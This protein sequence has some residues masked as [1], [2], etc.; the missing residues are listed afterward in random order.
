MKLLIATHTLAGLA[1][2]P[3]HTVDLCRGFRRAGHDVAVFAL[4]LG[5]LSDALKEEG[6]VCC[7]LADHRLL[8]RESFDLVYLHHAT[9]ELLLGAMFGGKVPIVRGYLGKRSKI[10]GPITGNHLSGALYLSEGVRAKESQN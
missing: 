3:L 7:S 6:F 2:A 9:T 8:S 5:D 1:G 4:Q 10:E